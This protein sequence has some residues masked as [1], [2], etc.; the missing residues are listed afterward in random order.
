M[1]RTAI[2]I[3]DEKKKW[4]KL[5]SELFYGKH[6]TSVTVGILAEEGAAPKQKLDGEAS[7]ATLVQVAAYNE[8][9]EGHIPARSFIRAPFDAH[10]GYI[11]LKISLLQRVIS[12]AIT[13]ESAMHILGSGVV[14]SFQK[15]IK[16][17]ILPLN[18]RST[19][20][21]K[22]SDTPLIATSQLINSISYKL[23]KK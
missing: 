18:A 10:Q 16:D 4:N 15:T 9:G 5:Q 23:D 14:K 3:T 6:T 8:F 20:K 11:K 2:K 22:E 7:N 17:I 19:E 12:G 21:R 1:P 13:L